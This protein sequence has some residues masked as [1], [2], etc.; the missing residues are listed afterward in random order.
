MSLEPQEETTP[1]LSTPDG[2]LPASFSQRISAL[3]NKP[4]VLGIVGTI[5]LVSGLC[6]VCILTVLLVREWRQNETPAVAAEPTL[7]VL[8]PIPTSGPQIHVVSNSGPM[9]VTLGT[10]VLLKL[11]G[12]EFDVTTDIIG[13]D[14]VWAPTIQGEGK[15]TW[16]SGTVVNYILGLPAS[17]ANKALLTQLAPGDEI[18]LITNGRTSF[19][20]TFAER[21]VLP[22]NDRSVYTQRTPGITLILLGPDGNDRLVV[23]GLAKSSEVESAPTNVVEMG[24]TAQLDN[25]QITANAAIYV[26]DR[27]EIPAGF[28]FFQVDYAIQN[29]G[30]TALDTSSLEMT[31]ID[32]LG[33]RYALNPAA[34][35]SGNYPILN[36]F[37]N[38]NQVVNA[39]AGYQVPLGLDSETVN[40]V[41]TNRETG[42]QVFMTLPFT[43]GETAA[44]GASTTLFRAEVSADLTSLNLG[45]QITNLGTQPLVVSESDIQLKT[46]EGTIYLLLSTNPPLPWTAPPGQTVQ[47]FLS[48]QRPQG[49]T[50]VFRVLNQEF[51]ITEL[52]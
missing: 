27:A 43:G 33:N 46:P 35:R 12:Q 5:I 16:I 18:Q 47:F 39:T 4:I 20:F 21:N 11:A 2:R 37:L 31:L 45:G 10:P 19:T 14:G 28:A 26:A 32:D 3:P 52:P 42:A 29:V 22:V 7:T 48:Y 41:V 38:A 9:T 34:S 30:L 44:Q 36:G 6:V 50:A 17:D 1:E 13:A 24:D 51:Q 15:A 40:W 8:A 25:V 23:H 49:G